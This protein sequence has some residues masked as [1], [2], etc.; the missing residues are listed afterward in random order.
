[1]KPINSCLLALFVSSG[2]DGCQQA[3]KGPPAAPPTWRTVF[4]G[5]STAGWEMVGPGE[6]K[7]ENGELVSYGGM[8]L[9]WYT[10]EKFGGCQIRV[11]YKVTGDHDNSGVFIRIPDPPKDPWEAVNRGYEAQINYRDDD[12]HRTGCL[13]SLTRA[14]AKPPPRIGEWSTMIITLSGKRTI[15]EVDG[16][17]VTD[18]TEGE[19]VPEKKQSYEPERGPRPESGYIGLQNHNQDVHVHF[20][21]VSVRALEPA[22]SSKG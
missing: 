15:V 21:E 8:G 1:M 6:L 3:P 5:G 13:Y 10:K 11:V 4:D 12:Y 20:K 17:R 2:M 9:L 16:D 14:Q 19:P 7:L 22:A 18:F